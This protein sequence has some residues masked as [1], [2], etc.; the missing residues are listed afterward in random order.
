MRYADK[1]W[2]HCWSRQDNSHCSFKSGAYEPLYTRAGEL[3]EWILELSWH[4][5][6][7]H[8]DSWS[9]RP[10]I[11]QDSMT[12][13]AFPISFQLVLW[14][15][16]DFS[17]LFQHAPPTISPAALCSCSSI[18]ARRSSWIRCCCKERMFSPFYR[19]CYYLLSRL[20]ILHHHLLQASYPLRLDQVCLPFFEADHTP[21][22]GR[23]RS[24]WWGPTI[25]Y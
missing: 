25:G 14:Y 17:D 18:L 11:L 2:L 4:L 23:K 12:F 15:S 22:T 6:V 7:I 10:N 9:Q 8:D 24:R 5:Q 3:K 13:H 1:V 20:L 16:R 21:M 19:F